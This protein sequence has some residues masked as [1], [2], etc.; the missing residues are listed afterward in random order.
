M[1]RVLD[2][3]VAVPGTGRR[4]GIEPIVGLIPFAGDLVTAVVGAWV[5]LEASRFRL[6]RVVVARMVVN[7]L[8]DLAVGAVP[9]LGDLL[10]FGIK[11]NSRNLELFRRHAR[12][13]GAS[14]AAH[15][16]FLL[17]LLAGAVGLVWLVAVL[18]GRLLS[19]EIALP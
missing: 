16:A 9:I 8:V 17:G 10:D 19:I 4:V 18:I 12:D 14:T 6:P 3:L 5:V 13:P 1:A 2:D 11:A 7:V 15:R